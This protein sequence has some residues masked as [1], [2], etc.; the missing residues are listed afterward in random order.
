MVDGLEKIT[1]RVS[2]RSEAY[3]RKVLLV[4]FAGSITPLLSFSQKTGV[5]EFNV[6]ATWISKNDPFSD[7]KCKTHALIANQC[8]KTEMKLTVTL[9][10][11]YH[12]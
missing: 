4:W 11:Y 3:G 9:R 6:Q 10:Y 8:F 2:A 5:F 12:L 1:L 7:Q